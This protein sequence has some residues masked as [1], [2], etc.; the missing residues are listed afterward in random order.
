MQ[1]MPVEPNPYDDGKLAE[2]RAGQKDPLIQYFIVRKDLD[3]SPGKI[4]AQVAHAAQ[5]MVLAHAKRKKA[6]PAMPLGGKEYLQLKKVDYW[7]EESFRKVVLRADKKQF[8][9]VKEAM[10]CFLVRDAGL[11]EVESGTETVLALWPMRKSEVPK[12]IQR[13]RVM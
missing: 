13:L 12:L 2:I 8:D 9:K 6:L 1:M 11:T 4:A 7:M 3:M 10:D 5:M